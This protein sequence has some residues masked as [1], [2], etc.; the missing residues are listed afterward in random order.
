MQRRRVHGTAAD[1][2]AL[3]VD[4]DVAAVAA[5]ERLAQP[6]VAVDDVALP[7]H[8]HPMKFTISQPSGGELILEELFRILQNSSS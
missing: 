6:R 4:G 1:I 5:V 3:A 7:D 8:L 2:A